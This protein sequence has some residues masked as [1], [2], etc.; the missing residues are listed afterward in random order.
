MNIRFFGSVAIVACS[1]SLLE[2]FQQL[3]LPGGWKRVNANFDFNPPSITA[4]VRVVGLG[5]FAL[6]I[7]TIPLVYPAYL[8]DCSSTNF[9]WQFVFPPPI[10][11]RLQFEPISL[12]HTEVMR[13]AVRQ[14]RW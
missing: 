1:N 14:Y 7:I 12:R 9:L 13:E 5:V 2:L 11:A 6:S 10:V 4:S 3:R 8:D